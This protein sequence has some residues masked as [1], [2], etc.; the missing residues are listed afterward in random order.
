LQ[1]F[2]LHPT[3]TFLKK[4]LGTQKLLKMGVVNPRYFGTLCLLSQRYTGLPHR[5]GDFVAFQ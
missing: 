5:L 4:G 3:K 2:A 1:G